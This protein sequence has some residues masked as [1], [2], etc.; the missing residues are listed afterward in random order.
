MII[1]RSKNYFFGILKLSRYEDYL[2]AVTITTLL[3][4]L[5]SGANLVWLSLLQVLLVLTSN[6]L[7]V[8]FTFMINDIEDAPDDAMNSEKS[9]RNPVCTGLL[10]NRSAYFFTFSIALLAII[11]AFFLGSIP[12]LLQITTILLGILYSWRRIRLKSIP[13]LDMVSHGF[14]LAGLQILCGYF[15]FTPFQG[16]KAAWFIPMVFVIFISMYGELLNE[17][18]DFETDKKAGVKHTAALIGE[19]N[20]KILMYVLLGIAGIIVIS[21]IMLGHVPVWFIFSIIILS[22]IFI[23]L[24]VFGT[25]KHRKKN[26][27]NFLLYPVLMSASISLF[28]W[29]IIRIIE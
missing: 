26:F 6:I 9:L 27:Y 2:F 15:S 29:L 17:V 1:A 20:A 23:F 14:M 4:I 28:I 22:L 11:S 19:V 18:R 5:F 8:C 12:F 7:A 10:S 25:F 3:G 16:F 13:V 21:S 24:P